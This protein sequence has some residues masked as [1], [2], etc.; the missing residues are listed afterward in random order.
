M[1]CKYHNHPGRKCDIK[2]ALY[3]HARALDLQNNSEEWPFDEFHL[4]TNT[5]FTTEAVKYGQCV[6]LRL[7]SWD[8]P[9][10][11]GL[12]NRIEEGNLHPITCLSTLKKTYKNSLLEKNVVLCRELVDRPDLLVETGLKDAQIRK[13]LK[14]ISGLRGME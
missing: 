14:E 8:Y 10:G 4:A 6:G 5:K 12:K 13:V 3:V 11:D 9:Q 7:L 1:E 2:V